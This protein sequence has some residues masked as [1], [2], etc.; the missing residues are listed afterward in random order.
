MYSCD[1]KNELGILVRFSFRFLWGKLELHHW[2]FGFL[3]TLFQ[4]LF[5][6]SVLSAWKCGREKQGRVSHEVSRGYK[7]NSWDCTVLPWV[8]L[9]VLSPPWTGE[10]VGGRGTAGMDLNVW[11]ERDTGIESEQDGILIIMSWCN[12]LIQPMRR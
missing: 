2:F 1:L 10:L 9:E 12:P 7:D 4:L 8:P 3:I 6:V 5:Q 11:L